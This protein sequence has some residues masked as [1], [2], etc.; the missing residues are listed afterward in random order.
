MSKPTIYWTPNSAPCRGTWLSVKNLEIDTEW[1]LL[2]LREKEQLKPEFLKINPMHCVP[3]LDD[4]GYILWESRAI[5]TYLADSRY[6]GGTSLYPKDPKIRGVIDARLYFDASYLHMRVRAIVRPI[7]Y[8]GVTTI[9]D[10]KIAAVKEA[11]S[12]LEEFLTGNAFLA[13]NDLTLADCHVLSCVAT[14][15]LVGVGFEN[16]PKLAEW[17]ERCRKVV[18]GFEEHEKIVQKYTD[19]LKSKLK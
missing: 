10:E 11:Y 7:V 5:S 3:T 6:P 19:D 14:S 9:S 1:R 17:Y 8:E 4:D 12:H 15:K 18:K 16:H 13:G 2:N